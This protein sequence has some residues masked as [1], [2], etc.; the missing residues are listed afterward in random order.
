M[1]RFKGYKNRYSKNNRIFSMEDLLRMT[2]SEFFDRENEIDSQDNL[3]GLPTNNELKNSPNVRFVESSVDKN[4]QSYPARWESLLPT[5][6]ETMANMENLKNPLAIKPIDNNFTELDNFTQEQIAKLKNN[7]EPPQSQLNEDDVEDIDMDNNIQNIID[8]QSIQ[9]TPVPNFDVNTN[10]QNPLSELLSGLTQGL[11]ALNTGDT[12]NIPNM[13]TESI[14]GKSINSDAGKMYLVDKN[15]PR[16]LNYLSEPTVDEKHQQQETTDQTEQPQISA[17]LTDYIND[18]V[19]ENI[20]YGFIGNEASTSTQ[21]EIPIYPENGVIK[22][23][24]STTYLPE[25]DKEVL[26]KSGGYVSPTKASRDYNFIDTGSIWVNDKMNK[27]NPDAKQMLEIGIYGVDSY[28]DNNQFKHIQD[29]SAD[30]FNEQYNL[31]GNKSIPSDMKGIEFSKESDFSKRISEN[32]DFQ[33]TVKDALEKNGGKLPDK[34]E[35]DFSKDENLNRSIGHA[36]LLNPKITDDGYIEGVVYDKYDYDK[37]EEYD[38]YKNSPFLN[39]ANNSAEYLHRKNK[40][41]YYYYFVP[42][43]FKY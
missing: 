39:T 7:Q 33:Q 23:G 16:V 43:K 38:D 12:A 3:I 24:I 41:E 19:G 34:I 9:E 18:L 25:K 27:A 2:M 22:G 26:A 20:D 15:Q 11:S 42:I 21:P 14:L 1:T 6:A 17:N 8:N 13:P 35:L 5:P 10:T 37:K 31:T 29:G 40:L 32:D 36:T 28:D 30:I 4:G